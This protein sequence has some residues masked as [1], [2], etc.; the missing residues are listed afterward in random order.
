MEPPD[1]PSI[2]AEELS[3]DG[4]CWSV[5]LKNDNNANIRLFYLGLLSVCF[6]RDCHREGPDYSRRILTNLKT[7]VYSEGLQLDQFNAEEIDER[8][9]PIYRDAAMKKILVEFLQ[10][11]NYSDYGVMEMIRR[12]PVIDAVMVIV[13][14]S[15]LCSTT[16]KYTKVLTSALAEYLKQVVGLKIDKRPNNEYAIEGT[17]MV[18]TELENF[19][20]VL[21]EEP[22]LKRNR[23][24]SLANNLSNS[25][26]KTSELW[27]DPFEIPLTKSTSRYEKPTR[28]TGLEYQEF[29]GRKNPNAE[30]RH[31]SHRGKQQSLDPMS[32][33]FDHLLMIPKHPSMSIGT[34][35]TDVLVI[36]K[37]DREDG[38]DLVVKSDLPAQHRPIKP[39]PQAARMTED[40]RLYI[41]KTVNNSP[42]INSRF[43]ELEVPSPLLMQPE[44]Q[45]ARGEPQKLFSVPFSSP[46]LGSGKSQKALDM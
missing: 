41:N 34:D 30:P 22:Y 25:D 16:L 24:S 17:R 28:L 20:F 1:C 8:Y 3:P 36:P 2:F 23:R 43:N 44:S 26:C 27:E 46:P 5:R 29:N 39:Y 37:R 15:I 42:L 14:R 4:K 45:F 11:M 18:I 31:P 35:D 32:L 19:A 38:A 6:E 13:F 9:R 21:K 40:P 10:L 12:Y 7:Q 33:D